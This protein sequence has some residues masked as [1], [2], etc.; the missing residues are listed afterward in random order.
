MRDIVFIAGLHLLISRAFGR[1]ALRLD[2]G[3]S[4]G[5][6]LLE[7]L[8]LDPGLGDLLASDF[9][10]LASLAGHLRRVFLSH[11]A[12]LFELRDLAGRAFLGLASAFG[13]GSSRLACGLGLG[14]EH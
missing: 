14:G 13:F 1:P 8:A 3:Q 4:L 6:C 7:Q 12:C 2:L 9:G 10:D 5:S 11:A